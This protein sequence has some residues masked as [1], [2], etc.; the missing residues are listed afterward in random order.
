MLQRRVSTLDSSTPVI[1]RLICKERQQAALFSF[2]LSF[3]FSSTGPHP[4]WSN[5]Q[6]AEKS[7]CE[8]CNNSSSLP[9]WVTK[10][11]A[12][13]AAHAGP[14]QSG[15]GGLWA[16][17]G[18]R[19]KPPNQLVL[20]QWTRAGC[21]YILP[22]MHYCALFPPLLPLAAEPW[23]MFVLLY[24]VLS[25]EQ[26]SCTVNCP[27]GTIKT[28]WSLNFWLFFPNWSQK[29]SKKKKLLCKKNNFAWFLLLDFLI[30]SY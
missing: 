30:L 13:L 11:I 2:F 25:S 8:L 6:W 15:H 4:A 10:T 12:L 23:A 22:I 3:F 14:H 27:T 17:S 26:Y 7:G 18:V 24:L 21:R 9:G 16:T 5:A 28:S 1:R 29:P 19:A 20:W